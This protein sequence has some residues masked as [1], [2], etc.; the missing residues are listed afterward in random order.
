MKRGLPISPGV[1]V[2]RAFCMDHGLLQQEALHLDADSLSGEVS[3]F[4]R[5]CAA[6]ARELDASI[7]RVSQQVGEEEA[8]IFR[9]HRLLLRDPT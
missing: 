5:A 4:D 1:A 9:A 8:A 6:V 2:A 7:E 3:R